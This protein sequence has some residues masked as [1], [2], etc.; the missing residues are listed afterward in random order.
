MK[1]SEQHSSQPPRVWARYEVSM[2]PGGCIKR[3]RRNDTFIENLASVFGY[4][5][6]EMELLCHYQRSLHLFVNRSLPEAH[7]ACTSSPASPFSYT[8]WT[9]AEEELDAD[10]YVSLKALTDCQTCDPQIP[11][12]KPLPPEILT[13]LLS[14]LHIPHN[15]AQP[16]NGLLLSF[17]YGDLDLGVIV[18]WEPGA[19]PREVKREDDEHLLEWVGKFYTFLKEFLTREYWLPSETYLPSAYAA[20]WSRAAI[21]FA[22]IRNFTPLTEILRNTYAHQG[23]QETGVLRNILDEYCKAMAHIIQT[24]KRGRIDKFMG[25][26]I[27]AVFGEHDADPSKAVCRAMDAAVKMVEQFETLR[28]SFLEQAFGGEYE[29]EYNETVDLHLGIGIDYGTVLFEYL[30]DDLHREYTAIGDHVNFAQRLE[31]EASRID[32][33]TGELMPPILISPTAERCICP[34]IHGAKKIILSP[35]GKGRAYTVYGLAPG[36]FHQALHEDC[37]DRND[38]A[39]PWE[40]HSKA[41]PT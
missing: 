38:W 23:N 11:P 16:G 8:H 1:E 28:T 9:V 21:L 32:E 17:N 26:G 25:D 22:D 12:L 24:E 34:W 19:P 29:T 35:K 5:C 2:I 36:N 6:E 18:L 37:L 39:G 4:M 30:G 14:S 3:F 40:K 33:K 41:K 27:M 15:S 13:R 7:V 20:R 31:K 10:S